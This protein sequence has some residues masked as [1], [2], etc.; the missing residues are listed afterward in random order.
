M[1]TM[2][3]FGKL[4][5]LIDAGHNN[6]EIARQL[7]IHRSTV[8]KYRKSNTA[9]S[10]KKR[11][12]PTRGDPL[13]QFD[14]KIKEYLSKDSSIKATS[15]YLY[16]RDQGYSGSLRTVERRVSQIKSEAPKERFFEQLYEPGEQSQLDFKEKVTIPFKSG[17]RICQLF[18]GTL[19]FSSRFF[20]KAFPNKT[21]EAFAD[22][23]HSFFEAIGGITDK[24]R[25]DN[26]SPAVK[27][28]LPGSERIY[29][30]AFE[31]ALKYYG[32]KPLPCSPGK[33]NEKGDCERDIRTFFHRIKDMIVMSGRVFDD[34][35][36]LN[37]WLSDF[38]KKQMSDKNWE[39]FHEEAKTLKPLPPRDDS[40][41]AQVHVTTVT[42]LGTA[43]IK[44]SRYSVPDSL[45]GRSVKIVVSAFDTKI[46]QISPNPTLIATHPRI[47]EN[48][49]SILL[50]H[51]ISSLVRKPQAMVRWVHKD[52]LFPHTVLRNYYVYLQKILP[53]GAESEFLRSLNLIHHVSLEDIIAGVEIILETKSTDPFGDLK[54]LLLPNHLCSSG[55]AFR[56][57]PLNTELSQYDQLIPA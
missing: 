36:D 37:Q 21:Y 29:T 25:F 33:G 6:S 39:K 10:Y 31:R 18:I 14:E 57:P 48:Q 28:V 35:E 54:N 13:S 47:P 53:H 46:Y 42:K 19:P 24:M 55:L 16:I 15:I 30:A 52:I 22:G 20:P 9:P 40:I 11:D 2:Y 43:C 27:K 17:D 34:F 4:R 50:E 26:L 44:R 5:Q 23:M 12:T 8:S 41:L 32:I 51:S 45:I 38:A 56:Q 3:Y 7:K 49:S 1:L